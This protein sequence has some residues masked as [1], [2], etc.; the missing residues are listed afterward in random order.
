MQMDFQ[1]KFFIYLFFMF[2]QNIGKRICIQVSQEFFINVQ[3]WKLCAEMALETQN[4]VIMQMF[5]F[6]IPRPAYT[7]QRTATSLRYTL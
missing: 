2:L 6:P 5:S 4:V 7:I 1:H 3:Y